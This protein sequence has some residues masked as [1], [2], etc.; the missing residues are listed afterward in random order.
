MVPFII[1]VVGVIACSAGFTYALFKSEWSATIG[2][3][4]GALICAASIG[5]AASNL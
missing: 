1:G 5:I 3:F 4:I 2:F